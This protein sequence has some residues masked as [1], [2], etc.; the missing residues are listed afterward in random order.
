[1]AKPFED[2]TAVEL[3]QRT[4]DLVE[5]NWSSGEVWMS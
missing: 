5:A 3:S 4:H 1:M 2:V